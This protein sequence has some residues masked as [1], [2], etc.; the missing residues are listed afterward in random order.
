MRIESYRNPSVTRRNR[1]RF[2]KYFYRQKQLLQDLRHPLSTLVYVVLFHACSSEQEPP[3]R[4]EPLTALF[5]LDMMKKYRM[6][7]EPTEDL[8]QDLLL[9]R[10]KMHVDNFA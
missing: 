5:L 7:T 10:W 3:R 4:T 8:T 2:E 9:D 1:R 6:E